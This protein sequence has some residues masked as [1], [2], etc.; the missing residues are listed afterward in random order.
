MDRISP[1][2]VALVYYNG[3]CQ[4]NKMGERIGFNYINE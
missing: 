2:Y 4:K 3:S 1:V